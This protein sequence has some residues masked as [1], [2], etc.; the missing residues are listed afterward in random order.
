MEDF[1][2]VSYPMEAPVMEEKGEDEKPGRPS[3]QV[4]QMSR[5]GIRIPT[6][7]DRGKGPT[8]DTSSHVNFRKDIYSFIT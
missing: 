1:E 8:I 3:K 5:Q 2:F 6:E 4:W 7:Q